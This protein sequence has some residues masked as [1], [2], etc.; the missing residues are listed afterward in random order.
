MGVTHINNGEVP[1]VFFDSKQVVNSNPQTPRPRGFERSLS[2]LRSDIEDLNVEFEVDDIRK[3]LARTTAQKLQAAFVRM[4]MPE[5]TCMPE[6]VVDLLDNLPISQKTTLTFSPEAFS[7]LPTAVQVHLITHIKKFPNL[8]SEGFLKP[9]FVTLLSDQEIQ[10]IAKSCPA[11]LKVKFSE[12]VSSR[13][14]QQ[15]KED[16]YP[17]ESILEAEDEEESSLASSIKQSTETHITPLLT[18]FALILTPLVMVITHHFYWQW[19]SFCAAGVIFASL[20]SFAPLH[21]D[22]RFRGDDKERRG[23]DKDPTTSNPLLQL[24]R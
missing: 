7:R 11:A 4:C 20:V 13:H 18:L 21:G 17:E 15:R 22:P 23:D 6:T 19:L 14:L 1:P 24:K 10:T 3:Y 2:N 12:A 8:H 16:H 5:S 9:E